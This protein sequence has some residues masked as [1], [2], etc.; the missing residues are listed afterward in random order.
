MYC[1]NLVDPANFKTV[2]IIHE[3]GVPTTFG[4]FQEALN[5]CVGLWRATP[6]FMGENFVSIRMI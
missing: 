1:I 3:D 2:H 6:D 4:T 5:F